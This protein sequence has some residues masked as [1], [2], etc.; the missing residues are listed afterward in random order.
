MIRHIFL[1][2]TATIIKNSEANTGLNPVVELNYGDAVTRFVLHFDE[3]LIKSLIEDKTLAQPDKVEYHLKMTNCMSV[4]GVPYDSRLFYGNTAGLKK[5]ASSF[6]VLALRLPQ[7]FDEGRGYEFVDDTWVGDRRSFSMSG[8]NWFQSS[9]GRDWPE[10]GVYSCEKIKEEYDKFSAGEES[11]VVTRQQFDFGDENLNLDITSYV[12]SVLDGER[13]YGLLLCF[14]PVLEVLN[15]GSKFRKIVKLPEGAT[16]ET[17]SSMPSTKDITVPE[18]FY[19]EDESGETLYKRVIPEIEQ[20]Y[21]GFFTDHTN[22]FFHPY[23][24][25]DYKEYIFDDREAFYSGKSN[26]LYLYSNIEGQPVN[27]DELPK[28]ELGDAV[29]GVEQVTKGVYCA[30]VSLEARDNQILCDVWGGL[31]YD[32]EDLGEVEMEVVVLPR[33]GYFTVD[34]GSIK[35]PHIVPSL[36]GINDDEKI[37]QED[38]REVVV[39]FRRKYTTNERATTNKAFYRLYVMNGNQQIDILNGYQPVE[40]SFLHNY[41]LIYGSDLIPG[42]YHVDIKVLEGRE[43]MFYENV[44][45]FKVR[46]NVTEK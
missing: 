19:V 21:V 36:Y 23:L 17:F 18:Y 32:G 40:H 7:E 26:K 27:L 31:Q 8:V 4:N 22:T 34:S 33:A 25:V 20:Q 9:N 44:L 24:E 30:N 15:G 13:N 16:A 38:V 46:D 10:A 43:E 6:T 29:Y 28:C 12:N 1:D 14:T 3:A 42:E 35:V 11:L 5:R 2:K 41:F 39:D 37:S 45:H